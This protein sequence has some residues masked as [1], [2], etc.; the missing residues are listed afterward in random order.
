VRLAVHRKH[1]GP[2]HDRDAVVDEPVIEFGEPADDD[3]VDLSDQRGP[4]GE[5]G[6]VSC[7]GDRPKLLGRVEHVPRQRQFG[8]D[9][10]LAAV[11]DRA[12][13]RGDGHLLVGGQVG[14]GG[15]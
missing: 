9:D 15:G 11:G 7:D 12:P 10:E 13:D 8:H 6:M 14:D 5:Y 1:A 4:G 2:V 3:P